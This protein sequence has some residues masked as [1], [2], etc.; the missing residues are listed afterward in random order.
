LIDWAIQQ[1]QDKAKG[2]TTLRWQDN[3]A[4]QSPNGRQDNLK[5]Q[6]NASLA[7]Q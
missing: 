5:G 6:V 3:E 2:K 7:R 1:K 4:R